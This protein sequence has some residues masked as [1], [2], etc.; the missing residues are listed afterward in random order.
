MVRHTRV[1]RALDLAPV[2]RGRARRVRSTRRARVSSGVH[3]GVRGR[4]SNC[5]P[6]RSHCPRAPSR[7][8]L[9]RAGARARHRVRRV[10]GTRRCT[11]SGAKHA[12]RPRFQWGARGR[13]RAYVGL[14]CPLGRTARE[15]HPDGTGACEARARHRVRRVRGTRR[16]TDSGAKPPSRVRRG[17]SQASC[18][19]RDRSTCVTTHA[20]DKWVGTVPGDRRSG[21]ARVHG[22]HPCRAL[23]SCSERS[24]RPRPR[25]DVPQRGGQVGSALFAGRSR[26][27]RSTRRARVSSGVHADVRHVRRERRPPRPH[28]PRASSRWHWRVRST[29]APSG[30]VAVRGARTRSS[31]SARGRA[32]ARA[33]ACASGRDCAPPPTSPPRPSR[34]PAS[35]ARA[36]PRTSRRACGR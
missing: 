22:V 34:R 9:A 32:C 15:H 8:A 2:S 1:A 19:R 26:R 17:L 35:T 16:C 10:R 7:L 33:G 28:C 5:R 25:V 6:P 24:I 14:V 11:A 18:R 4:T 30:D 31:S 27:V 12:S 23:A 29:R 13:A 21:R 3:A 20:G 36:R